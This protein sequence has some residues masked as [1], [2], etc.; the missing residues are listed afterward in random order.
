MCLE[1]RSE[2]KCRDGSK[3]WCGVLGGAEAAQP[4]CTRVS[5][6]W[7]RWQEAE[8]VRV[9]REIPNSDCKRLE[10]LLWAD[11]WEILSIGNHRS[12]LL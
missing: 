11:T 2:L 12:R 9:N 3:G 10:I 6:R 5:Q 4:L 1:K 8:H 7:A